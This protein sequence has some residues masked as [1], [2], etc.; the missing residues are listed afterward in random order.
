MSNVSYYNFRRQFTTYIALFG[1]LESLKILME[2]CHIGEFEK[3][4]V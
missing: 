3:I 1:L 4:N 2:E